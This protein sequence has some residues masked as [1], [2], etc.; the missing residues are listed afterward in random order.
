M[1]NL[2]TTNFSANQTLNSTLYPSRS[3][4]Q[5]GNG[6]AQLNAWTI[7]QLLAFYAMLLLSLIGNTL[8]I[9]AVTGNMKTTRLQSHHL[10]IVNLSVADS[11]FAVENIPIAFTHLILNGAWKI[12]GNFGSFLCK[13]DYFLSLVVILTSNLTILATGVERF[14]GIFYPLRTFASKKRA[15]VIIASTWLASGIYASPLFSSTFV[16]L[17]RSPDGNMRCNLSIE[18]EKV[19]QWFTFQ[20]VLIATAFVT[21]LILYSAIGVKIWRRK[22]PGFQLERFQIREQTKK[23][24][25]LKMLVMLVTV[26]YISFIPFFILQ[27]S[28]FFGFFSKLG[29]HYGK[30][31]AFLMYCNGA[32]NPLIYSIYND[33]IREQFKALFTCKKFQRSSLCSTPETTRRPPAIGL[34]V[35]QLLD[36]GNK[37]SSYHPKS[38][39]NASLGETNQAFPY[40]E[41][42]L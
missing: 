20:T 32:I 4:E 9:K 7:V 34:Q 5:L 14:H 27:L 16:H 2:V 17:Q 31:A 37:N 42:R 3:Q 6:K 22:T 8:V 40:E 11:L 23:I 33:R 39:F 26:F 30:I 29:A 41:T 36:A 15:Y 24:K 13:F 28:I 10:F 12:E 18:C 35:K 19:I 38:T 1:A 25:T 21:T